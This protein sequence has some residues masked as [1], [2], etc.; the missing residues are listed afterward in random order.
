MQQQQKSTEEAKEGPSSS[1]YG[2]ASLLGTGALFPSTRG[3]VDALPHPTKPC[4]LY[5]DHDPL[6]AAA[7]IVLL[8]KEADACGGDGLPPHPKHYSLFT[9]VHVCE[10]LAKRGDAGVRLLKK[11]KKGGQLTLPVLLNGGDI[12]QEGKGGGGNGKFER[13]S[14]TLDCLLPEYIDEAIGKKN[15]L[16]PSDAVGVY[17]MKLVRDHR[18][19][20]AMKMRGGN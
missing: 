4:L 17:N 12:F 5:A 11:L 16:R 18:W 1:Y 9:T 8:E 14:S 15:L 6:A 2:R 20:L 13:W 19:Q 10:P 3:I 7:H